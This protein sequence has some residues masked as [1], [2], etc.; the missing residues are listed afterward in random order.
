M[1]VG[2]VR[3][4][5]IAAGARV[6]VGRRGLAERASG[7]RAILS[8]GLCGALDPALRPGDLVVARSVVDRGHDIAADE[9]WLR[10]LRGALPQARVGPIA[11][12]DAIAG[13]AAAKVILRRD[14]GAL[15][16]DMESHAVARAAKDAG[17]PFAVIRAVSDAANRD[18]PRSAQAGFGPDGRPK[19]AA[20]LRALLRRPHELPALIRT[21]LEAERGFTALRD[22]RDL[23]GPG[24]GCP[25][26]VQHAVDV[27]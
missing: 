15:A 6:A 25:Y 11:G 24:L 8:F 19:V 5:S 18:L 27:V 21:A 26:L 10:A 12:A 7:A 22:A 14:T 23:L 1:V 20:V 16:V 4:G 13:T 17:L 2:L 9:E 3:E